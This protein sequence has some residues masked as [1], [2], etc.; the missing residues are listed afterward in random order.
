VCR[1][2]YR[3]TIQFAVVGLWLL[4]FASPGGTQGLR[5]VIESRDRVF[6]DLG[7]GVLALKEDSAGRYYVLAKPASQIRVYD[8]NGNLVGQIPNANSGRAAIRYAVDI[9]LSPDGLLAV[10]DRGSNAIEVFRADG[11][12][13]YRIPV[14]APTSVVALSGGQFAVTSL[15]SKRL[16]Q[17]VDERGRV[18]RSFGD[19]RD[20]GIQLDKQPLNDLGMITGDSAGGIYFAFT[21][22]ADPTLRKF[23]RYGYVAYESTIP[24]G[25]F[26][27]N[28]AETIDRLQVMFGF[29][30]LSFEDQTSAWASVGS[31]G[32]LRFG[33]GVGT[34]LGEMMGRGYGFDQAIEQQ[35]MGQTA[36]GGGPVGAMVS[37]Q[38]NSQGSDLQLG[39]GR[40]SPFGGGRRGRLGFG[41][42]ADGSSEQGTLLQFSSTNDSTGGGDG[43]GDRTAE[44]GMFGSGDSGTPDASADSV[45]SNGAPG[46]N[47][48]ATT[49]MGLPSQFMIGSSLDGLYFHPRGLS[50]SIT[51]A[52]PASGSPGAAGGHT[53]FGATTGGS[54]AGEAS[55]FGNFGHYRG[56]FNTGVPAFTGG[57]RVNLGDL[58]SPAVLDKPV[59]T[60]IAIDPQTEEIWAGIGDT[61]AHFA[62][63]GNLV[64][65]Y[66]LTLAGGTSLKPTALLV[67]P[68]RLLIASDPWGVFEFARPDKLSSQP[69]KFNIA[70]QVVPQP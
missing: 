63:D 61:L 67:E 26:G 21:S 65:I 64:G 11:S 30:D 60:A 1:H 55:H 32:A 54:A 31:T 66:Y 36:I 4:A 37:G 6:P 40:L 47:V 19:P 53:P 24:Q 48:Y 34:G 8:L 39:V 27:T 44:L 13:A 46:T 38:L 45:D 68:D 29:T 69:K 3:G 20:L 2:R 35:T 51:K 9:D 58:S 25:T 43:S 5:T 33:G 59:I 28:R 22:V 17:V 70:P 16:V 42:P 49:A 18:V 10:A 12:L 15:V 7:A 62:K 56:R 50:E 23:D 57:V 41:Q 14:V 52:P